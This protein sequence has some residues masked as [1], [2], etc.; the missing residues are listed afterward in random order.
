MLLD[1]GS[2]VECAFFPQ[3]SVVSIIQNYASGESIEITTVGCEGVTGASWLVSGM[4]RSSFQ[5]RVQI[6]GSGLRLPRVEFERAFE[7]LPSFQTLVLRSIAASLDHA[8]ISAAC[9]RVHMVEQ[10]LARWLLL[11]NDRSPNRALPLTQEILSEML[12]VHRPTV[13]LAVRALE[14]KGLILHH[15]GGIRIEDRPGLRSASCECYD[16]MRWQAPWE[17]DGCASGT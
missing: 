14:E 16:L 8:L 2:A 12:G 7:Q 1:A 3:T 13:S 10:R 17:A 15:R 11:A 5:H 4:S 6:A 9:N